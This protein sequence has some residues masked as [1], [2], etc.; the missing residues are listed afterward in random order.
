MSKWCAQDVLVHHHRGRALHKRP[1][2]NTHALDAHAPPPQI[3][4]YVKLVCKT[5]WSATYMGVPST[6]LQPE[7]FSGWMGALGTALTQPEPAVRSRRE[8]C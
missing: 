1:T 3:S 7:P 5:F 6:L 2:T 8:L 4:T